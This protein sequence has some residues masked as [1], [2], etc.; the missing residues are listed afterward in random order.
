M[1]F[2]P[3]DG[4]TSAE[5]EW[6]AR[7]SPFLTADDPHQQCIARARELDVLDVNQVCCCPTAPCT[8]PCCT[9]PLEEI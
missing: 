3:D 6:L 4:A 2:F 5:Q 8:K 9:A 7:V 1:Q